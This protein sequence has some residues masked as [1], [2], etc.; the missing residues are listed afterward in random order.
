MEMVSVPS[1]IS[2]AEQ[3]TLEREVSSYNTKLKNRQQVV[4]KNALEEADFLALLV[5][6]LQTQDPCKPM[7]DKEF[8]AQMAQ[9]TSLKQMNSVADNMKNFVQ[10]FDFTKSVSLVG[11]QIAWTDMFG[12]E[13]EGRVSSVVLKGDENYLNVEGEAV[14]IKDI[15]E[16]KSEEMF[17]KSVES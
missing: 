10:Q 9:L 1:R 8:M 14:F 11:K 3:K 16:V 4:S 2:E 13:H 6:Q 17:A 15:T 5:K 12:R 7:D